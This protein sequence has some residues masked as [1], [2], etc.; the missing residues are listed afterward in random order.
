MTEK[1]EK[2]EKKNNTVA[3]VAIIVLAV[4][5]VA[6]SIYTFTQHSEIEKTDHALEEKRDSLIMVVDQNIKLLQDLELKQS[7][8]DELYASYETELA[9]NEELKKQLESKDLTISALYKYKR[10]VTDLQD[11]VKFY[12]AKADSLELANQM[13]ISK[14]DSLS[15]SLNQTKKV[16]DSVQKSE[17]AYKEK[18]ALGSALNLTTLKIEGVKVRNSGKMVETDKARRIDRI[19]VC[20]TVAPNAIAMSEDKTFYIQVTSPKGKVI[21]ATEATTED[22]ATSI[23]YSLK[24]EFYYENDA[25]DICEYIK[26]VNEDDDFDKGRYRITI[27]NS[28]LTELKSANFNMR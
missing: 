10:N 22:G 20:F 16:Y 1:I 27:F 15:T 3:I 23:S 19:K 14:S 7:E 21:G 6:V 9:E 26:K 12:M 25:L 5:L 4:A 28:Q 8:R 18:V 24:S 11:K 17:T 2:T 13:L